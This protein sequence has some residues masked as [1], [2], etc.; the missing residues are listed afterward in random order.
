MRELRLPSANGS[1]LL[2]ACWRRPSFLVCVGHRHLLLACPIRL[3]RIWP[4]IASMCVG[5]CAFFLIHICRKAHL[6]RYFPH[7]AT[8]VMCMC[9]ARCSRC[10][11]L[12][13]PWDRFQARFSRL[14]L[15]SMFC[16][17]P[18]GDGPRCWICHFSLVLY[19]P[20]LWYLLFPGTFRTF[21]PLFPSCV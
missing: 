5:L 13:P 6:D 18:T 16:V 3:R 21:V 20:V 17:H 11:L 8:S 19:L 4:L 15:A 10:V 2:H 1:P 9:R 12:G 14:P 7:G